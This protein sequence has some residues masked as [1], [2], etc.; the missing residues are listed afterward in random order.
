MN[1]DESVLAKIKKLG[2]GFMRLPMDG[3]KV[4]IEAVCRM[5]DAFIEAGFNYFDTAH[6]YLKGMSEVAVRECVSSKYPR[7]SF[8]LANKLS[9]NF[10][11]KR[12]DIRP[13]FE[14][15]LSLCGVDYFD[16]YLMH[17]QNSA[18]Y[19]K[20]N[21][22]GAYEEAAALRREGKIKH[23]GISFHD[24]AEVLE[25]ILSEHPEI[26]VVQLQLN[27]LDFD[28]PAVDGRRNLEVCGRYGKP[29]LVMEPVKGGLLADLP[30]DIGSILSSL[31]GGSA[32]SYALRF[33][34]TLPGVTAV[35][36]GMGSD[37]MVKDNISTFIN[38]RELDERESAAIA[39]VCDVFRSKHT[40]PC[41]DCK[42]CMEVC[43]VGI[44]I[45]HLFAC[46][47]KQLATGDWSAGYYY[48][49]HTRG[50]KDPSVCIGCSACERA[51][52][53]GIKI[54]D[55]LKEVAAKFKEDR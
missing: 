29:V 12:E 51:C 8:I 14:E 32:A 4:D 20:Y 23:I 19:E 28:D 33:A 18:I 43:P 48:K 39:K 37:K 22:I 17:S 24:R 45:P 49:I 13:L 30:D 1:T 7:E 5:T 54:R 50:G 9:T 55:T 47:N 10:F 42:Y 11:E 15:Q 21:R 35:L 25:K 36:S 3:E 27:Y 41:T 26:E 44:P 40:I 52:P 6:G 31:G 34:A 2:F 16:V 46:Y 38:L 53:Q